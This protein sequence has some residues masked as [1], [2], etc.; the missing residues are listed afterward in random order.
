MRQIKPQLHSEELLEG[1]LKFYPSFNFILRRTEIDQLLK[2]I[3]TAF[4]LVISTIIKNNSL[5]TEDIFKVINLTLN[6]FS[7]L[8]KT[9]LHQE[10]I[11]FVKS[12][13]EKLPEFNKNYIDSNLQL[14][15]PTQ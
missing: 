2:K 15:F 11:K 3:S 12:V 1:Y 9:N 8:K 10:I 5:Y 6:E 14:I 13:L 4:E 7:K